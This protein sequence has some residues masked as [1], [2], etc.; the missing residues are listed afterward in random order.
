MNK[1]LKWD[2]REEREKR[3]RE[4]KNL[5]P[6]EVYLQR[7]LGG[8]SRTKVRAHQSKMEKHVTAYEKEVERRRELENKRLLRR[9]SE[10]HR[11]KS[12]LSQHD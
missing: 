8:H 2:H 9:I 10:I 1:D 3:D 11:R 7:R 5:E 4:E 6:A 12:S